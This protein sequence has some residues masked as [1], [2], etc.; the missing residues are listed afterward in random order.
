MKSDPIN[1]DKQVNNKQRQY[2]N[3]KPKE[4]W[5]EIQFL[6]K[7]NPNKQPLKRSLDL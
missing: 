3:L 5:F 2:Q 6:K 7:N 1:V 4:Q